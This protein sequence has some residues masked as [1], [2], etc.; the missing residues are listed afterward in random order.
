MTIVFSSGLGLTALY[1]LL[2]L[3]FVIIYRASGV[4]NFAHGA[5]MVLGGYIGYSI[6]DG[7]GLTAV[8]TY[9]I[10]T[11]IGFAAGWM[12]YLLVM[13]RLAGHPVWVPVLVTTGIGFFAAVGIIGIVWTLQLQV[14]GGE[15]GFSAGVHSIGPLSFTSIEIMLMVVFVVVVVGL[16]A[17]YRYSKLGI[18][19]RAASQ[20]HHLAA[21]RS[22][23]IHFVFAL[24]WAISTAIA[25]FA[26]FAY[27]TDKHLDINSSVIVFKAFA[28][29]MVGGMTSIAGAVVGALLVGLGETAAQVYLSSL[30]AELLPFLIL[31]V[32]LLVRP[33]GIFGKPELLDRV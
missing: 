1:G 19:M 31:F 2:A 20:D 24:A 6:V 7:L 23:N 14:F 28:A 25:M 15:L 17:F 11:T 12:F 8:Q 13:P 29:A 18:Q 32:I 30:F 21:Y 3:G 27:A 4:L 22:I 9:P 5:M 33:W 26:G 10:V 16:L